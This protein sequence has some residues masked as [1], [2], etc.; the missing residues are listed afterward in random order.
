[1]KDTGEMIRNIEKVKIFMHL[2]KYMKEDIKKVC[3]MGMDY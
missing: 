2:G 1:M 3:E